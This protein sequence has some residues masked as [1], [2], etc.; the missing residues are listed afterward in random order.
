MK[1]EWSAK[2]ANCTQIDY[3][4]RLGNPASGFACDNVENT[5]PVLFQYSTN[6]GTSWVTIRNHNYLG[7]IVNT[8][9]QSFTSLMPAGITNAI[10]T[11]IKVAPF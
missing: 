7:W 2:I 5:D 1:L 10:F 9:W 8:G 11:S 6:G 3:A 4:I